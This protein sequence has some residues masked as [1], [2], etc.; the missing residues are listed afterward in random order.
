MRNPIR[1]SGMLLLLI[2][3]LTGCTQE[4]RQP[5]MLATTTST[6]QT[7]LLAE[8]LPAFTGETGIDVS[9][10]AVGTGQ[11]LALG[12]NGEAD[13]LLVHDTEAEEAFVRDGYAEARHEVMH[14]RFVLVGPVEDPL[15]LGESAMKDVGSALHL[16]AEGKAP[17]LSRGDNSGTHARERLL[18]R[19]AG[20]VPDGGWY[21]S[22]GKGMG[23]TLQMADEL[24]AYTL[25][26]EGTWLVM[27]EKLD[28]R[29]YSPEDPD[30]I[31]AYGL[32]VV[33]GS[34]KSDRTQHDAERFVR[35]MLSEPVQRRIG[36]F[37]VERYG[38]PLFAPSTVK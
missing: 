28:L 27:A 23:E 5:L 16:L 20:I 9:V 33:R 32:L 10:V 38:K 36:E 14:N 11:A 2:G 26:D 7:G 29:V 13:V 8:L 21:L 17:F 25:S 34:K 1:L 18:W 12:R 6:E 19:K 30:L 22:A 4:A 24:R 3:L 15:A 31:N 35:W 37:G